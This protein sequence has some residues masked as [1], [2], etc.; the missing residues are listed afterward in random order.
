MKI[1]IPKGHK[2][3]KRDFVFDYQS[4][5]LIVVTGLNGSGKTTVLS[6][7]YRDLNAKNPGSV[8]FKTTNLNSYN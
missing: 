4:K 7:I 1:T 6:Y 5:D 8:F 2:G 3:F